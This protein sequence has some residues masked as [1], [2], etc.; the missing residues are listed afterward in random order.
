MYL[1]PPFLAPP[2]LDTIHNH[3]TTDRSDPPF[4]ALF[5]LSSLTNKLTTDLSVDA[6]SFPGQTGPSQLLSDQEMLIMMIKA[7]ASIL[8]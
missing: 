5:F 2:R 1:A 8:F 3:L 7:N 4:H 6:P